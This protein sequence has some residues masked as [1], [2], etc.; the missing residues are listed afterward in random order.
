MHIDQYAFWEGIY[1]YNEL[2]D[3]LLWDNLLDQVLKLTEARLK[4]CFFKSQPK[5]WCF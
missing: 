2:G 4:Q 5:A 3:F 1:L